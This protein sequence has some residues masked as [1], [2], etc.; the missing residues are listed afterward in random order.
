M[1]LE[2]R[3][4]VV[5]TLPRLLLVLSCWCWCGTAAARPAPSS[6]DAALGSFVKSW[7]AGTEYPALC[8]ASL[9]PYAAAVRSSP[10]RLSWA[11]LK[12]ALG[13]ARVAAAAMEAMA[14][15]GHLAPMGAE[16]AQDCVSMLGDAVDLLGQSVE[17]MKGLVGKER[18]G[19]QAAG[20]SSRNVRF[21]VNS[22]QTWASAA[23]TN[24]DMCME[25]FKPE[26]AGGGGVR[27]VVH[28]HVIGGAHLTAIALGII[29]ALAKQI[30]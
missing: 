18:S 24:D 8:D 19:G 20:S 21:Q 22:V 9:L 5:S 26:A 25:G 15:A 29:N 23:L 11:A 3:R 16:A 14:S 30:P 2:R 1:A 7:C 6:S 12:V 17:A 13:G 28:G 10:A 4:S 27:E